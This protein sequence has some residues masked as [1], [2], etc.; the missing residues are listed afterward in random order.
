[1]G[2]GRLVEIK[3]VGMMKDKVDWYDCLMSKLHESLTSR[4]ET[5]FRY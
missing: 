2:V 3:D 5:R 1:M 4:G